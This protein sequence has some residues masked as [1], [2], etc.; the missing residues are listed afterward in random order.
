MVPGFY[1]LNIVTKY[2][3]K[4]SASSGGLAESGDKVTLGPKYV[5]H[6]EALTRDSVGI[7]PPGAAMVG[8]QE[9]LVPY[10]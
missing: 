9:G 7:K 5:L 6:T 4:C 10:I 3:S 2:I 1:R 8:D